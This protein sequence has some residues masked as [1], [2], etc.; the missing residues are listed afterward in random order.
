[1]LI[2]NSGQFSLIRDLN[3][4]VKRY[5][6]ITPVIILI[7]ILLSTLFYK[8]PLKLMM[9]EPFTGLFNS[10]SDPMQN[11][12]LLTTLKEHKAK[13]KFPYRYLSDP[14]GRLLPI[15]LVSGFFRDEDAKKTYFEYIN[16]GIKVAGVTAYKSFPKKI[17]DHNDDWFHIE[18]DF[19]YTKNI[20]DWM[21]CF[22]NPEYYG[23][24]TKT[25]HLADISE[26]DFYDVNEDPVPEK[27][28][29][30]IYSCLQDDENTCPMEAWNSVNRNFK[31]ALKC[32]PIIMNEYKLKMLVVGRTNCGLE[33]EYGDKIE[34]VKMLPYHE[35]Q[36]KIKQSKFLFV[37]N[38]YDASPRVITES[39]SKGLPVLMNRSILCGSK[40]I[41][42]ETGEAFTDEYDIRYALDQLLANYDK[43]S[44]K[45]WWS[46]NYGKKLAGTKMCT[47]LKEAF[48]GVID[49]LTEVYY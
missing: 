38:I 13:S 49:N 20:K 10:H 41:T 22:S 17:T 34:V 48:P 28:Y 44:P 12:Y 6:W 2:K 25:H 24:S 5:N 37:P 31:T 46:E 47:F 9:S 33:A 11:P 21:C 36:E 4:Y 43:M 23:L 14:S 19:D 30:F 18:D 32:F 40:Y 29:D 45:K 15:V 27:K 1:M 39:I 7:I 16:N 26:S 35:F 3:K 8:V 42:P